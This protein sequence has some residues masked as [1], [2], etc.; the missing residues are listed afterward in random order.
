MNVSD[1]DKIKT[2][3][4]W[5]WNNQQP[6][7]WVNMRARI[8]ISHASRT[9]WR[10]SCVE[11][12]FRNVFF[13]NHFLVQTHQRVPLKRCTR[14]SLSNGIATRIARV[15]HQFS[16]VFQSMSMSEPI[17]HYRCRHRTVRYDEHMNNFLTKTTR[18]PNAHMP[19]ACISRVVV[20]QRSVFTYA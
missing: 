1:Q 10:S 6:F 9:I 8:D 5:I 4:N 15:R 16:V 13:L 2:K 7:A 12:P 17:F 14:S 20:I 11:P 18:Y 3:L 19:S